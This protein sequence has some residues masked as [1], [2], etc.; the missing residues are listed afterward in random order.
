M[1]GILETVSKRDKKA[2]SLL[3]DRNKLIAC[4]EGLMTDRP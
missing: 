3:S 4:V 1:K 2:Y